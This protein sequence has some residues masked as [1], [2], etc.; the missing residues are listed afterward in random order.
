MN[1]AERSSEFKSVQ[2]VLKRAMLLE[3]NGKEFFKMAAKTATSPVA[4]ELFE[5]MAKEEEHHLHILKLTFNRHLDEGKVILPSE[6]E[7]AF[8]FQD[9][10]IDKSFLMEL[11]NSA[12]D[13]SA[14]SI[15]LTL[16]ERAFK[17][18]QKEEQTATDPDIKKLFT[19]L[20]DWEIDHHRKLME[21]EED[22]REEVWNDSNFWPM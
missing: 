3:M 6:E 21:L 13:S 10:I 17:F 2:D 22:F 4:K 12:F 1:V 11:R 7:L 15:A 18:Y 14:I 19:W 20:T 5:H 9:P 8:G 16:E